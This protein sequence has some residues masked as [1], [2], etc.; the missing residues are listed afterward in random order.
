MS[1]LYADPDYPDLFWME[2]NG[3]TWDEFNLLLS[4]LTQLSRERQAPYS[5]IFYPSVDM[6]RGNPMPHL[7]RM[8][9]VMDED[10]HFEHMIAIVPDWMRI[11]ATFARVA[12]QIFQ[13]SNRSYEDTGFM[14][15]TPEEARAT[16]L[17]FKAGKTTQPEA[18]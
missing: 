3:P 12:M 4:D 11:A 17:E 14:V 6:P 1:L 2:F 18:Q 13:P 10:P 8:M 9:R 7:K 5:L 15:K 16:Y